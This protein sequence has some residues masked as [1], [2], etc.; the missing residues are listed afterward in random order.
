M[1]GRCR[2][3]ERRARTGGLCS[4]HQRR[5]GLGLAMHQP[6][7]DVGAAPSG[8]GL[9]G[10]VERDETGVMCH[11]CGRWF[12]GL[13]F[14]V[15]RAHG[16]TVAEYRRI[17]QLPAQTPLTSLGTSRLLGE[18]AREQVGS[19]AWKRFEEAR[20]E[21]KAAAVEASRKASRAQTAGAKAALAA[22]ARRGR[23][24]SVRQPDDQLWETH[25]QA[26]L[27]AWKRAGVPPT[28]RSS[29]PTLRRLGSWAK[30]QWEAYRQGTL[31][32]ARQERLTQAGIPLTPGRG[33]RWW[34]TPPQ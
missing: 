31:S 16:M 28:V 17:H 30:K 15:P 27:D 23:A 9:L 3:C 6:H 4:T 5:Q 34:R 7:D 25:L 12:G 24:I 14:H 20:D 32:P 26:Y 11:E 21:N 33:A 8:F 2:W 10:I 18:K 13:S 19:A 22:A 1:T 29:D